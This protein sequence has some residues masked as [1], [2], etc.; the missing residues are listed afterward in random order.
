[1]K[2]LIVT[3]DDFG[4]AV[5]VNEAVELA[6]REGILTAASLMMTA[7]G[8]ADAVSRARRLPA[9][10]VGLHLVLTGGRPV[11]PA[12]AVPNLVDKTGA[13]RSD[14]IAFG[15][16]LMCNRQARRQLSAEI[17]AQ[18]EAFR[19]TGLALDHC[20]AHKHFHLHPVIGSLMVAIGERFGLCS[21]RV[22]HE[23]IAPLAPLAAKW[24]SIEAQWV[25]PFTRALRRKVVNAGI[26]APD[27]V[28]GLRWSGQMTKARLLHLICRLPEGLNE[29][30]LH[31]ATGTFFGHAKGYRYQ[32]ELAALVDPDVIAA[33]REAPL[34]MGGYA[35]FLGC[36]AQPCLDAE[37]N[38]A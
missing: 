32:S 19:A 27:Q 25:A 12:C 26:H 7:P 23:P 28:F 10:R 9:L 20:N 5:E 14:L 33:C 29:I 31:P 4:A 18:F 8:L 2:G 13:F 11:L 37:R 21:I 6:H 38:A 16:R 15:C 35:D 22:P 1:L 3:A 24:P 34:M 36:V 30:Y 17:A